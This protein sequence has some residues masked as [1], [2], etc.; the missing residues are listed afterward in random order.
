LANKYARPDCLRR[1]RGRFFDKPVGLTL[2]RREEHGNTFAPEIELSIGYDGI[3]L[4]GEEI[5]ERYGWKKTTPSR[6]N[7]A[8]GGQIPLAVRTNNATYC[9]YRTNDWQPKYFS[10]L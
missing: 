2:R 7:P 9:R 1:E 3:P 8:Y 5:I 10:Y 4:K 6:F